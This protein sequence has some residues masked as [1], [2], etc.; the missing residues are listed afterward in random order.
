MPH[1][2]QY[3]KKIRNNTL[4]S[5]TLIL[6]SAGFLTRIMGFFN[7]IYLSQLIGAKE[8][9]IYQLIFP[10]YMIAFAFCCHGIELALSQLIA[11]LHGNHLKAH[12]GITNNLQHKKTEGT[13]STSLVKTALALSLICSLFF[14]VIIYYYADFISLHLIN[15]PRS[16]LCLKLLAPVLPFTAIRCCLHG[17]YIG[18][19][20]TL[21]PAA[22]QLIEQSTRIFIIWL[23]AESYGDR[24]DFTAA[25]AVCGMVIGEIAGTIYT[26]IS[27]KIHI[28]N[29]KH[30]RCLSLPLTAT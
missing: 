10:V 12:S 23:I 30:D 22:G 3:H 24:M 6:T 4:I 14:S 5:G 17:Y 8:M 1:I 11:S 19:K 16:A 15:E 29:S 20:R 7:R 18:T 2:S 13:S 27:Y 25:L 9:G 28:I 26:Y 21:V